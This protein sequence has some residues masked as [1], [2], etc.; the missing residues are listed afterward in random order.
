MKKALLGLFIIIVIC[1]ISAP[2]VNGLI[3]E[4]IL[5]SQVEKYNELYAEHSFYP[6]IEITNYHRSYGSSEIEW[7]MTV[8]Y[9]QTLDDVGPIV[10]VEKAQHGVFGITSTT[11]LN[12]NSGYSDFIREN[13]NGEDPLSISSRYGLFRGLTTTI[14]LEQLELHDD[15]NNSMIVNPGEL[16]I[17]AD[18]SLANIR[19]D[20]TFAGISVPGAFEIKGIELHSN[21]K[22]I[23]RLIVD[24]TSS[25]SIEQI[26]IEDRDAVAISSLKGESTFDFDE[27]NNKLSMQAKYS[28]AQIVAD[29]N[30][31]DDVRISFGINQLDVAGFEAVYAVYTNL[32]NDLLANVATTQNDPER[33][34]EMMEK[35]MAL[36]GIRLVAEAEKLLKKDL[37]IEISNLHLVLPQGVVV[38]DLS[39]GLKQDMTMVS[40]ISLSQQPKKLV[41]VFSFASNMS[42]PVGLIPNQDNLLSP[43]FPG[44]QTGLFEEVG[45][46]LVHK[47]EITDHQLLLNG[48][49]F[50]LR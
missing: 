35:E 25:V 8:P 39:I 5:R 10:L 33:A 19:T 11:H 38:G 30:K 6:D 7:T 29:D 48:K 32:I 20:A 31:V 45:G 21:I 14:A 15:E 34:K 27:A 4:N 17:R 46:K 47:A 50:Q 2:F 16:V 18:R 3:L 37:Q 36:A 23:S 12:R 41:E 40:F 13:L 24:G 28:V 44:M 42:L 49:E 43:I 1:A 22:L 26:N 9:L